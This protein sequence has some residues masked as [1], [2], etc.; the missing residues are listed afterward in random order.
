MLFADS[1]IQKLLRDSAR[2][3]LAD[4]Y[5]WDRLYAFETSQAAA[6]PRE[7]INQFAAMGWLGLVAPEEHGGG[8]LSLVEA[9][10]VVEELGF[11]AVPANVVV[12]NVATALLASVGKT[13]RLAGLAQAQQIYTISQATRS[14]ERAVPGTEP[15]ALE[16]GVLSGMLPAV[17]HAEASDF[18]LA[19]L[20][21]DGSAGF[22]VVP[23]AGATLS[24]A[25]ELDRATYSHVRFDGADGARVEVL[26]TGGSAAALAE[27][28]D[29]LM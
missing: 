17:P 18:V 10:V 20:L 26:G 9:A 2:S 22:A 7:A 29:T 16:G 4:T 14:R 15:L 21:V 1:E 5:S 28:C 3:F 12:S 23:L 19:A 24:P 13:E 6:L 25:H 11:A 27:Q 8:G